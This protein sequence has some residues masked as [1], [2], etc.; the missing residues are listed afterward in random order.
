MTLFGVL[1]QNF[2]GMS[3]DNKENSR[4]RP[5]SGQDLRYGRLE[6]EAAA[7]VL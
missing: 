5:P 2:L 3:E 4:T 6:Y 1:W 7:L